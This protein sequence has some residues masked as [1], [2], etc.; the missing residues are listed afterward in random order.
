V[1]PVHRTTLLRAID[2]PQQLRVHV[3]PPEPPKDGQ[4]L[5]RPLELLCLLC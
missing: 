5:P 3:L 1:P 4:E 2:R